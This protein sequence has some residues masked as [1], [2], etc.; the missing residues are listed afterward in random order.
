MIENFVFQNFRKIELCFFNNFCQ[1]FS[2][3]FAISEYSSWPCRLSKQISEIRSALTFLEAQTTGLGSHK[4]C[5][6]TASK[7][8]KFSMTSSLLFRGWL[9]AINLYLEFPDYILCCAFYFIYSEAYFFW[10]VLLKY[11]W[12]G[13]GTYNFERKFLLYLPQFIKD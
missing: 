4:S 8:I 10:E 5:C 6:W 13:T 1:I 7:S 3:E 9:Q 12:E 11:C 2:L